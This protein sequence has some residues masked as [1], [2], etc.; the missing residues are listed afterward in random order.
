MQFQELLKHRHWLHRQAIGL[1]RCPAKADDLVQDTYV[2]ILGKPLPDAPARPW[3]RG[4]LHNVARSHAR[5][6]FRRSKREITFS[7]HDE[8]AR[9]NLELAP[10]IR[11]QHQQ[12]LRRIAQALSTISEPFH[13]V[14]QLRYRE[15]LSSAEIAQRLGIPA[16]TVRWRQKRGLEA[17]RRSL[18]R[19]SKRARSFGQVPLI[20]ITGLVRGTVVLGLKAATARLASP[21]LAQASPLLIVFL[22][23]L[24]SW[25]PDSKTFL[26][27]A[28][29]I[30]VVPAPLHAAKPV[31]IAIPSPSPTPSP[32]PSPSTRPG[33]ASGQAP[34]A[35]RSRAIDAARNGGGPAAMEQPPMAPADAP[36]MLSDLAYQAG[37][38]LRDPQRLRGLFVPAADNPRFAGANRGRPSSSGSD[39]QPDSEHQEPVEPDPVASD[40]GNGDPPGGDPPDDP[41]DPCSRQH[42]LKSYSA[43]AAKAIASC[44]TDAPVLIY[45]ADM[46]CPAWHLDYNCLNRLELILQGRYPNAFPD[47]DNELQLTP[48]TDYE[49]CPVTSLLDGVPSSAR[50]IIIESNAIGSIEAALSQRH[51]TAQAHLAEFVEHAGGTIVVHLADNLPEESSYLAPGLSGS[52]P[53]DGDSNTMRVA[54]IEHPLLAGP[55]GESGTID[56]INDDSIAWL[57]T[58][59][60]HQGSLSGVLPA[61]ATVLITGEGDRPI[62]AEYRLGA[63]RVIAS[64]L[65]LEYGN[66]INLGDRHLGYG[67]RNRLLFNHFSSAMRPQ[68]DDI[69]DP[70]GCP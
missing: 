20:P 55:D 14:L 65:T 12:E 19:Q 6:E 36:P 60:A 54:A 3:L 34:D 4:V 69:D 8:A 45:R 33:L 51:A 25:A 56:D 39:G 44:A 13:E 40:P 28:T 2:A 22:L 11:I 46:D 23:A 9:I 26:V 32:S 30:A 41:P 27:P 57:G 67:H 64:T 15:G 47:P 62:Y 29:A 10:D 59:F 48:G 35:Q 38:Q 68:D 61:D 63:G 18:E 66:D 42:A 50:V 37:E 17:L 5:S 7:V 1:V 31:A 70:V 53:A 58:S 49:V 21:K 24:T 43:S 16:G 52:P